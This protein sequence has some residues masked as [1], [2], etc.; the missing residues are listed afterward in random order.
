MTSGIVMALGIMVGVMVAAWFLS[1]KTRKKECEYDEMQLKIRA[2]GYQIGFY[3]ALVLMMILVL[4]G[5]T[6]LLTVVT[7]GF[8]AYAALILSVTVFAV[9]CILHD[10]FLSVRGRPGSHIWI[11][12]M[13]VL[14][15]GFVAVRYI[16]E[17]K[18]LEDGKLAFGSGAP[19]L[20]FI[21]FLV[22]LV[23]LIV[24]TVRGGKEEEE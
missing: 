21:C 6:G 1:R 7:P 2:R 17:G 22:I 12:G 4:L 18:M 11:F 24:K 13:V 20:M 15:E 16:A 9:Y 14:V 23:T 3:T 19:A 8:A 5:E 10:A